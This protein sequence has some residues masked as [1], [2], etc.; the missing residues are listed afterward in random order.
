[1]RDL[2]R[3]TS[4]YTG[5]T[6]ASGSC[7]DWTGVQGKFLKVMPGLQARAGGRGAGDGGRAGADVRRARRD[8]VGKVTASWRSSGRS[9]RRAVAERLRDWREVYS[10]IRTRS[11]GSRPALHGLWI[12][13]APGC[14]LG[15]IIPDWNDLSTRT[16]GAKRS[17]SARHE[18]LPE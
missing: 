7:A 11:C 12:P 15:N 18:Q 14:P 3:A 6:Y 4:S 5:S 9:R 16:T 8:H 10:P 13:S 17:T 1:V 2:I